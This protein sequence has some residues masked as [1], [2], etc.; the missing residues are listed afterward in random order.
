MEGINKVVGAVLSQSTI[1]AIAARTRVK[2]SDTKA[3]TKCVDG[4]IADGVTVDLM[5]APP[6]EGATKE[7]QKIYGQLQQ[8]VVAGFSVA[9][10]AMLAG[11]AKSLKSIGD[12]A[13][14]NRD[15]KCK[16][17][18]KYWQQQIGSGIKDLRVSLDK[19]VKAEAKAE[20]G[21]GDGEA[22]TET[23]ATW[24]STTRKVLATMID[25]AQKKESTTIKDISKFIKDLQS[26]MARIP[27]DA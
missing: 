19:R 5:Y 16:E 4:L 10:Q 12:K 24:E 22:K 23:A 17:N 9:A 11:E 18:R 1:A 14:E 8:A 2:A 3:I 6:K 15:V 21:E 25:Q 26:A 20:E 7:H 13:K 27:A